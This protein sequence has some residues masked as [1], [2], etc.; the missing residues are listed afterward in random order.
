MEGIHV[1]GLRPDL[2][3]LL[4]ASA[5]HVEC[6]KR[7]GATP[8]AIPPA[9]LTLT[10]V[11]LSSC[12]FPNSEFSLLQYFVRHPNFSPFKLKYQC[13]ISCIMFNTVSCSDIHLPVIMHGWSHHL[14][15]HWHSHPKN[16]L[17]TAD[18]LVG[19]DSSHQFSWHDSI[20]NK[21]VSTRFHTDV[22]LLF[23][24]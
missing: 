7:I 2:S 20:S 15:C 4:Y 16:H 17:H 1:Y 18:I 10:R 19:S 14:S 24:E 11:T 3:N 23:L 12:Q 5:R 9:L 22:F 6:L 13:P 21:L 8:G